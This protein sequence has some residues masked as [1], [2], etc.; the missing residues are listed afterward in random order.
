MN[1]FQGTVFA[2]KIGTKVCNHRQVYS[3]YSISKIT[4]LDETSGNSHSNLFL[5]WH[6][7]TWTV[8]GGALDLSTVCVASYALAMEVVYSF[9]SGYN[10]CRGGGGL[11]E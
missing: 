8:K 4:F 2:W 7:G 9:K 10:T 1:A 3:I 6:T 11:V 5:V